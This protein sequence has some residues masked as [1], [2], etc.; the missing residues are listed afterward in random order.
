MGQK[1]SKPSRNLGNTGS[2]QARPNPPPPD[3]PPPAYDA[4]AKATWLPREHVLTIIESVNLIMK[5]VVVEL[6]GEL[7]SPDVLVAAGHIRESCTVAARTVTRTKLPNTTSEFLFDDIKKCRA[8]LVEL[9]CVLKMGVAEDK[10]VA[11]ILILA[12]AVTKAAYGA[13]SDSQDYR[14]AVWAALIGRFMHELAAG[15]A[16]KKWEK[17]HGA[18]PSKVGV[19]HRG[20]V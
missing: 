19:L 9:G 12:N 3:Q 20:F 18:W 16:I 8:E 5:E 13:K 10:R 2:A 7:N 4:C 1:H 17:I 14:T 6:D 15:F 11:V